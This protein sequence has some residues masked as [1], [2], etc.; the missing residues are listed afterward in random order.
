MAHRQTFGDWLLEEMH[1]RGLSQ[2]GLAEKLGIDHGVI[3]RII[4]GGDPQIKFLLALSRYT[5]IGVDKLMAIA[6]PDYVKD[7]PTDVEML[8][9]RINALPALQ[10]GI[11]IDLLDGILFKQVNDTGNE[12][13]H[14]GGQFKKPN[15]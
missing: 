1:R 9:Q 2:R 11:I 10:R 13:N 3:G 14:N 4:D 7:V 8:A 15:H 6:F 5:K 12:G